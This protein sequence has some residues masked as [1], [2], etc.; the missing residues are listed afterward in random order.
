MIKTVGVVVPAHNEQNDILDCLRTVTAAIEHLATATS[1]RVSVD[2][3]VVLDDCNDQTAELLA[4]IADTTV[5][6]TNAH[7]VGVARRAGANFLLACGT[8]WIANTDAD[9]RVHP[10][11]LTRMI[12]H[13][14][15]GADL[16]LGTVRPSADLPDFLYTRWV[17]AHDLRDGH[18]H[19][20]G[21]NLGVRASTYRELGGWSP[22]TTGEDI[23]LVDR[24][25]RHHLPI[26]RCGDVVVTTSSRTQSRVPHGF[27]TY[28]R[29]LDAATYE[30]G[31][32][33]PRSQ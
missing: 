19:V 22:L 24:A 32:A 9:S 31:G 21:A 10:D 20:H 17:N 29:H 23:D 26:S 14:D 18:P 5:L 6:S 3:V 28:L 8:D 15:A 4:P 33:A 25:Q 30:H 27:A 7:S 16:V 1:G 13:A 2:V 12:Y 11:W